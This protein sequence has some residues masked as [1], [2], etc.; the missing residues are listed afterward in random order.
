MLVDV[1]EIHGAPF[2]V[3]DSIRRTVGHRGENAACAA[4]ENRAA[5]V[6]T[7]EL[8]IPVREDGV[9]VSSPRQR[10]RVNPK[11]IRGGELGIA[12]GRQIDGVEGLVVHRVTEGER[13]GGYQVIRMV[14]DV[15]RARHDTAPYLRY[16]VMVW[17]RA[18]QY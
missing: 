17:R 6:C 9:V 5:R 8:V 16:D 3:E 13:D 11:D 2:D 15:R 1:A 12:V 7:G 10:A 4:R 14:A 18:T